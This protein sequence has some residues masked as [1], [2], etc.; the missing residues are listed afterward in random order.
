M[1][2]PGFDP[3]HAEVIFREI[4]RGLQSILAISR[5]AGLLYFTC[6]NQPRFDSF[7]RK[8]LQVVR[9]MS[10][11]DYI[12]C[13]TFIT[14]FWTADR[15]SQ[16]TN[17]ETQLESLKSHWRQEFGLPG[18]HLYQHGRGYNAEGE[19]TESFINWFDDSGRDQIAQHARDMMRRRYCGT[20]ASVMQAATPQ[21]VQEL[22][23]GIPIHETAAGQ[24]LGLQPPP[25]TRSH[26]LHQ[27]ESTAKPPI[28]RARALV[29]VRIPEWVA[30]R[31]QGR[32]HKIYPEV[33][34]TGRRLRLGDRQSSKEFHGSSGM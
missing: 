27:M 23:R 31:V 20:N 3:E 25:L 24:V 6:I 8:V 9:A 28:H 32:T 21:I 16:Q 26:R 18:L 15:P 4:V 10:G 29:L 11:N 14:T 17:F 30:R 7:D 33:V 34:Q 1:D 22:R 13:V 5:I 2:T 12:P 19:V